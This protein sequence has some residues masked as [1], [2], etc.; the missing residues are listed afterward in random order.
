MVNITSTTKPEYSFVR[1]TPCIIT[2]IENVIDNG[3]GTWTYDQ[4][5]LK[6]NWRVN[7][8]ALIS[9]YYDE[10]LQKAKDAEYEAEAA[11]VRTYRD[12]LLT[13]CDMLYTNAENWALMDKASR[14]AWQTYKQA[15][16]DVT[17]QE[18][19]PYSVVW[20]TRPRLDINRDTPTETEIL[21]QAQTEADLAALELDYRL[22]L[23][24]NN[25]K[26]GEI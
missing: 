4:Y 15:L 14:T 22:T 2:F 10:W 17:T 12:N 5:T 13:E 1:G 11:K 25:V 6:E 8:Q 26:A 20:P 21:Q 19:F 9:G 7:L 23:I 18:S 24:E 16:R 3:D